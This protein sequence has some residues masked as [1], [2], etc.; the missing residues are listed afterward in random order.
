METMQYISAP[1]KLVEAQFLKVGDKLSSGGVVTSRPSAG[2]D[3]PR[4]KVDLGVNG[5]RKTWNK[6]TL[7]SIENT[8]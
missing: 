1:R 4:G 8:Q 6:R 5:Y 2:I 3:T 7:I